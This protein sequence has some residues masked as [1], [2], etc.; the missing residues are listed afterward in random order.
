M[1]VGDLVLVNQLI[2]QLSLPL[3]F[4]GTVYREL[5]QSLIDMEVMFNL[6]TVNASVTVSHPSPIAAD[7]RTNPM[8]NPSLFVVE[9]SALKT[10]PLDTTPLDPSSKTC[11]LPSLP[12]AKSPSLGL[13][14]VAN[15]QS[16]AFYSDSTIRVLE[17]SW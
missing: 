2:F 16:S 4:L 7:F 14:A 5:R 6:Q 15:L 8:S 9:K 13:L 3:N 12:G 11:H 1:T 10:W 17:K